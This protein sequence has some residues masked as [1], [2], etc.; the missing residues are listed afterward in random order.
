LD[1]DS[2]PPPPVGDH[3]VEITSASVPAPAAEVVDPSPAA[4]VPEP[5]PAAEVAETSSAAGAVTVEEVME[6]VTS[7]YI[8]FPGVGI[9]DLEA[10]ELPSKALDVARSGCLPCHQSWRR[11]RRSHRRC[12][13]TSV[14]AASL[15]PPRRRRRR[16]LPRRL[17]PARIRSQMR[18]R[19]RRP[20]R[21][22]KCPSPSQ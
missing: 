20:V 22:R 2:A 13:S 8:D 14:P 10:P 12:I 5:S 11:S 1:E 9:V 21:S 6:M 16:Q 17:Q 15:P 18:P 4:E 19:H 3:D 7:R